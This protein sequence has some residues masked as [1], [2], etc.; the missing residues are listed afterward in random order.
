MSRQNV[1]NWCSDFKSGRIGQRLVREVAD[2]QQVHPRTKH[3]LVIASELVHDLGLSHG[4]I[5]G[6]IQELSFHKVCARCALGP[7]SEDQKAQSM[8]SALSFLQ[9]YAIHDHDF[10]EH[11][12]TLRRGFII[13]SRRQNVQAWIGNTPGPSDRKNSRWPSVLANWWLR[14]F[15]TAGGC[16]WRIS[17]KRPL[18]SMQRHT[19]RP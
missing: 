10:L 2:W 3:V 4:T 18:Q 6:I 13:T 14:C 7:L 12:V 19:T 16:C 17:W 15:G 11:I 9:Q 8:V 5:G 1:A